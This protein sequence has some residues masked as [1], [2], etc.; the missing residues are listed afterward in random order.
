M[1]SEFFLQPGDRLVAWV[2]LCI[3]VGHVLVGVGIKVLI[4]SFFRDFYDTLELAGDSNLTTI[5]LLRGQE[6]V[7]SQLKYFCAIAAVSAAIHPL[8]AWVRNMWCLRWRLSLVRSYLHGFS[9]R[10]LSI[11]GSSQR[12]QEDSLKFVKGVDLFLLTFFDA[13][14]TLVLFTPVLVDLGRQVECHHGGFC[15]FGDAWIASIASASATIA[16]VGALVFGRRLVGLEVVNQK[17]EAEFRKKLVLV[18][19]AT[20]RTNS[21]GGNLNDLKTNYERLYCRFYFLNTFLGI[22]DQVNSLISYLLFAKLL[23]ATDPDTRILLGLLV[24]LSNSFDRVFGALSIVSA[25]W[26]QMVEFLSVLRRLRQFEASLNATFTPPRNT[27]TNGR[28]RFIE[29]AEIAH[30]T[31]TDPPYEHGTENKQENVPT[32]TRS[33][34]PILNSNAVVD[35]DSV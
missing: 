1:F 27:H 12:C 33:S 14:L 8:A 28:S 34:N 9:D 20:E 23:F 17:V 11:E 24:Q 29:L 7:D 35:A 3:A 2:G 26:P 15:L 32:T 30:V 16:M 18:E 19:C 6:D 4:N 5:D 21:F 25:N 22:V 31:E 13:F 10:S